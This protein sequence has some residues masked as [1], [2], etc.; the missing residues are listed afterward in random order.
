MLPPLV[1]LYPPVG[2]LWKDRHAPGIEPDPRILGAN[3]PLEPYEIRLK[4][5]LN[6]P[7]TP[8]LRIETR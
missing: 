7:Y 1:F 3:R 8:S 4:A 5:G 2:F 6:F